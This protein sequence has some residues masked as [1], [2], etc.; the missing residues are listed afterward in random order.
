VTAS[1]KAGA[2]G[3]CKSATYRLGRLQGRLKAHETEGD[4]YVNQKKPG[5]SPPSPRLRK[6]ERPVGLRAKL[7][8]VQTAGG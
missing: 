4:L 7:F 5:V 8:Q 2:L 1:K 6:D 3:L